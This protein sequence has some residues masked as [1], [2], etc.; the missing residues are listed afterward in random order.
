MPIQVLCPGC[1]SK[2]TVSDQFAGRTGPCPKCRRPITVPKPEAPTVTIHE[3]EPPAAAAQGTGRAP[4][5]PIAST[6]KPVSALQFAVVGAGAMAC[7]LLVA[8]ARV[9]W[10]PG[11]A[12]TWALATAALGLAGPCAAIGYAV[13]RDRG[14]EPYR[15]RAFAAR[16]AICAA[17]YAALW[18]IRAAV[19]AEMTTEMWQW[20]YV[21]PVFLGLGGLAAFAAFDLEWGTAVVHFSLYVLVTAT[22][23]WLA[24]FTPI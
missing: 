11:G 9:A 23:R 2:F 24:G 17:A 6:E 21:G 16:V 4:T 12:P 22:L 19:P 14:L 1:R 20:L 8:A 7:L 5:A 18:G 15:G 13:V 10:P 3:P